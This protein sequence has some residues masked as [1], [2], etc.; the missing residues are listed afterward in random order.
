[1][2]ITLEID[3]DVLRAVKDLAGNR[4]TT[5]GHVL[6]DLARRTLE[7]QNRWVRR[8]GVPVLRNQA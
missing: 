5:A 3:D 8:N 4:R 6:S 1:M 7:P 2:R